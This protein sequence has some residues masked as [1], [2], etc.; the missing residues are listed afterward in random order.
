MQFSP[1]IPEAAGRG[2]A[3]GSQHQGAPEPRAAGGGPIASPH[4]GQCM[5]VCA[6]LLPVMSL[7][8]C[9]DN[10]TLM[11]VCSVS[12]N[13]F[14]DTFSFNWT[15]MIYSFSSQEPSYL[16]FFVFLFSAGVS[17]YIRWCESCCI[18]LIPL[19]MTALF[20]GVRS[21]FSNLRKCVKTLSINWQLQY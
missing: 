3:L 13:L 10:S 11:T 4:A 19:I 7:P 12:L 9:S 2:S 20:S 18:S 6:F 15:L 14:P 16:F 17:I 21:V 5:L 8:C 1:S